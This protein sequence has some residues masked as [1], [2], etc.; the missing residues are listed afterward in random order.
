M[1]APY[2]AHCLEA[3]LGQFYIYLS[4]KDLFCIVIYVI[5]FFRTF[6]VEYD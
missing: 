4:G 5:H 1:Y 6:V 3:L 2:T